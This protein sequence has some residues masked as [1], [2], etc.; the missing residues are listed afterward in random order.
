MFEEKNMRDNLEDYFCIYIDI[1]GYSKRIKDAEKNN[2]LENE[3]IYFTKYVGFENDFWK[4][5]SKMSS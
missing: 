3:L 1:L 5:L 2:Q 4:E